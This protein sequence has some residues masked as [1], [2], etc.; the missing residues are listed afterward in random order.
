MNDIIVEISLMLKRFYENCKQYYE[1]ERSLAGTHIAPI[2]IYTVG[3][4]ALT[5]ILWFISGVIWVFALFVWDS[6]TPGQ[7]F[8]ELISI[9]TS[10]GT[11]AYV[12]YIFNDFEQDLDKAFIKLKKD[13]ANR[14]IIIT[15]QEEK[16]AKLEIIIAQATNNSGLN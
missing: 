2:L 6:L 9:L 10:I 12:V 16:I 1:M 14:T 3:I 5:R 8:I 11:F 7:K 13:I 4:L 15:E